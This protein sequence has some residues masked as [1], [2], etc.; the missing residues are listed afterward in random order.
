MAIRFINTHDVSLIEGVKG[1]ASEEESLLGG[2]FLLHGQIGDTEQGGFFFCELTVE[3]YLYSSIESDL[4][5]CVI[6]LS[7]QGAVLIVTNFHKICSV[8]H[9]TA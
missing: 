4:F 6:L 1:D 7:A 2:L 9:S 8:R 5:I 3:V